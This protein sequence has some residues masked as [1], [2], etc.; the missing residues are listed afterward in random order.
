M[1]ANDLLEYRNKTI[2]AFKDRISFSKHLK[3]TVDAAH[4]Y[5]L[6]CK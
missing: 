3:K 6:R 1:Q 2:D 5:V 4:G